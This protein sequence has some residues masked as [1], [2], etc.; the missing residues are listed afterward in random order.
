MP[1]FML[2]LEET[3]EKIQDPLYSNLVVFFMSTV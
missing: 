2:S 1:L 3:D